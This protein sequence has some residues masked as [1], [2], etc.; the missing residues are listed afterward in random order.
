MRKTFSAHQNMEQ[1][2]GGREKF[3]AYDIIF[4]TNETGQVNQPKSSLLQKSSYVGDVRSDCKATVHKLVAY[5][6]SSN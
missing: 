2:S 6:P 5:I 4:E 3:I 1:Q